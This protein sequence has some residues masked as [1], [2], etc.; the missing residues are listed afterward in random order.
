MSKSIERGPLPPR[1]PMTLMLEQLE[2]GTRH[3]ESA[4]RADM[5]RLRDM[6]TDLGGFNPNESGDL[7][8]VA[9]SMRLEQMLTDINERMPLGT[10]FNSLPSAFFHM[11]VAGY[12]PHSESDPPAPKACWDW[13]GPVKQNRPVL[14]VP[15]YHLQYTSAS[16]VGFEVYNGCV[17]KPEDRIR[18]VLSCDR[19]NQCCNPYH[20]QRVVSGATLE[21]KRSRPVIESLA[22]QGIFVILVTRR[23]A[24]GISMYDRVEF[25]FVKPD[26]S[27][28]NA[29]T[30]YCRKPSNVTSLRRGIIDPYSYKTTDGYKNKTSANPHWVPVLWKSRDHGG[31]V[32]DDLNLPLLV[33]RDNVWT[34]IDR[35]N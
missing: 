35:G 4:K 23:V 1:S 21:G 33:T 25:S 19:Q 7:E 16:R 28:Q 24:T 34:I 13:I 2:S 15:G 18:P 27:M 14:K 6:F 17:L 12:L 11:G 10:S 5:S 32:P 31:E 9:E 3:P 22:D 8:I 20:W 29:P 26:A 30:H